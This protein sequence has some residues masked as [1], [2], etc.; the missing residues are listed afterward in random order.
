MRTWQRH[1][2]LQ[3]LKP[4]STFVPVNSLN[5]CLFLNAT[6][7]LHN[8]IFAPICVC[9]CV[10]LK[11]WFQF[12]WTS[13]PSRYRSEQFLN[14]RVEIEAVTSCWLQG[15]EIKKELPS[16]NWASG[17]NVTVKPICFD[18]FNDFTDNKKWC[19]CFHSRALGRRKARHYGSHQDFSWMTR[20]HNTG[21]LKQQRSCLWW[22]IAW[23]NR[24]YGS[25]LCKEE[26]I[27]SRWGG[28][29]DVW[30][31]GGGL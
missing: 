20:V 31:G 22:V 25:S 7:S 1:I 17:Y 23:S 3:W 12:K 14:Q 5:V 30:R 19:G 13:N 29:N 21:H 9:V 8:G 27:N 11:F 24:Q 26:Q 28:K 4:M 10:K 16:L 6:R 18:I 2:Q 15:H